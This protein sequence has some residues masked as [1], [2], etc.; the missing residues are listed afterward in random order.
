MRI[1]RA[2]Y[3]SLA[4]LRLAVVG[5]LG[6]TLGACAPGDAR[7][8]DEGD[9]PDLVLVGGTVITVDEATPEAQA[10][11]LRDGR[12]LAVG[13]SDEIRA[14]AGPGTE[15]I[16][17]EGR[18]VMP[19]FIEGHGHFLGLGQAR[20]T[21]DLQGT[22]SWD[23]IVDKVAE[24]VAEAEPGA[25]ITGRG[26][27]QERW[28]PAPANTFDGVPTHHALSE[29]SP[30]N[31]VLL[32]HA[33]GHASLANAAAM[34]AA[35]ITADTPDPS[36]GTFVRDAEGNPTGFLR[37]AA[38][39]QARAAL[40]RYEEGMTPD[41]VQTRFR[42]QVELA[43]EDALRHGVTSFHD[44]GSSFA[45]VDRLRAMADAGELP[46]R[47]HLA[48][49]GESNQAMDERLGDYR[50]VGH[51]NNFLTVRAVKRQIDGALGTHGAWLLDPYTDMPSTS[52]L[53]QVSIEDLRE[54]ADIALRHGYQMNTHAIGDRGNREGLDIYADIM[55]EAAASAAN[56]VSPDLR[57]RI[58]HA[59]N[60]HPD[61]VPRFADMGVIASMQGIHATSDGPWVP[62]RLGEERSRRRAY[63]WRSLLDAD[64]VICNGTDVPV[65]PISPIASYHASITRQMASGERFFP[66][67][68]MDR[69]E[70]L[71][72]YTIGC[73]Y[74]V[75]EEDLLG[76]ITPGKLADLVVL[77]RNILT[78]SEDEVR[79]A[80]VEMTLVGGE[81]RYRR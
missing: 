20:M 2:P 30:D 73:A 33:S 5:A 31:P 18:V 16:E 79:D 76:S 62:Q 65:E 70:A 80:Q 47:L 9:A 58:E 15:V 34:E 22:T 50:M 39:G 74:A 63:V 27:H 52:G 54:T 46:I 25:W 75:F 14:L 48:I 7:G 61:E 69:L 28:S 40:N 41:E 43:G 38:Q 37:Q 32:T 10:V 1:L 57:W 35:G 11:A 29:V 44:Q 68:S 24:A 26:W 64:A 53:P 67:Q 45:D 17:L 56:G 77:D 71:R 42:R 6:F 55:A 78:V 8:G 36:G 4:L 60:L 13:S 21:V 19:G 49:R 72:S 12:I 81:I 23:Q 59:Q 3:S 51:G 66:E